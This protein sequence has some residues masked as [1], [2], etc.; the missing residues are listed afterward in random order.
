[1]ADDT[2]IFAETYEDITKALKWVAIYERAT[3]ARSTL[4]S[5]WESNGAQPK[6]SSLL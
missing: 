6:I 4:T 3:E 1:L 2:K 5:M